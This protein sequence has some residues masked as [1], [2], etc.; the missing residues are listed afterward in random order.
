VAII[1]KITT[2]MRYC[3]V[4]SGEDCRPVKKA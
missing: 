1:S 3:S 4:I 2:M